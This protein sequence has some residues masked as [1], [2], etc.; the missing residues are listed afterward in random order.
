VGELGVS[1]HQVL[2]NNQ[3]SIHQ[4]VGLHLAKLLN[5]EELEVYSVV[6]LEEWEA[7][8]QLKTIHTIFQ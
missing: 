8:E 2:D 4:E 3:K 1:V 5:L 6:V 7:L